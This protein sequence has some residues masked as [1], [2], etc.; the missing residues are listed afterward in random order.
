MLFK[1]LIM[2]RLAA[3]PSG[4]ILENKGFYINILL[5]KPFLELFKT[6]NSQLLN[7]LQWK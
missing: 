6:I 4:F 2:Y 7:I 1:S 3:L 5:S